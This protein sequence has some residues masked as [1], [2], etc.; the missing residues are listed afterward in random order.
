[1]SRTDCGFARGNEMFRYR[2]G[3]IIVEDGCVLFATNE[4]TNY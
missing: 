3:A 2:A 4:K 1:M